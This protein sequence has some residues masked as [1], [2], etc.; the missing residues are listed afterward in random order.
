MFAAKT[1]RSAM[2]LSARR[3]F[4]PMKTGPDGLFGRKGLS[5]SVAV[6]VRR[7]GVKD[8]VKWELKS[9]RPATG[10][11]GV[12][13]KLDVGESSPNAGD[14][15]LLYRD[16]VCGTYK[17]QEALHRHHARGRQRYKERRRHSSTRS[18]DCTPLPASTRTICHGISVVKAAGE[19]GTDIL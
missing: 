14:F 10:L 18:T 1:S 13:G 19:V 7:S 8:D 9:G 6:I 12:I 5:V 3:T 15:V 4:K 16:T 11:R 2:I 17:L